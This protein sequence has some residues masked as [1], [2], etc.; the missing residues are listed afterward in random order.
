MGDGLAVLAMALHPQMKRL[1]STQNQ[2]AVLRTGG[3]ATAVLDEGQPFG[4][5]I[6]L[7]DQGAHHH[8]TVA[9]EVLGHAV[10]HQVS[11]Q[12]QRILEV[13]RG[14]GVVHPQDAPLL[15]RDGRQPGD[16]QDP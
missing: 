6:I 5:L 7:H 14:E 4:Q 16:V 13:G 10:H 1:Q 3:G 2:E 15:L 12:V 9:A 8:V 11:P